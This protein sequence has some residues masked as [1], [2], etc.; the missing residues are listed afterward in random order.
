MIGTDWYMPKLRK[1]LGTEGINV[2]SYISELC[3]ILPGLLR[4]GA[5][6]L[7]PRFV[8]ARRQLCALLPL[9]CHH[10]DGPVLSQHGR[11][12]IG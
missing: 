4:W 6:T 9:A 1:L 5:S 7:S 12:G 8:P 11:G 10:S 2:T 3:R